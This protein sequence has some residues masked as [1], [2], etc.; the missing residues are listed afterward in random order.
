V[1]STLPRGKMTNICR[2]HFCVELQLL[3]WKA[4][5]SSRAYWI[6]YSA[7][8]MPVKDDNWAAIITTKLEL[9]CNALAVGVQLPSGVGTQCSYNIVG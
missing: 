3:V 2:D 6:I 5:N 8:R 7:K 1:G 4:E 9:R